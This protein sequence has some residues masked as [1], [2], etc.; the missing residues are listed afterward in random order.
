MVEIPTILHSL[1]AVEIE[2]GEKGVTV[3]LGVKWIN[4]KNTEIELC[5]CLNGQHRIIG[6]AIITDLWYGPFFSLPARF[7]EKEHEISSRMYSGLMKSMQRA[8]G[9]K[10]KDDSL[11]VAL[12]YEREVKTFNTY[13][14]QYCSKCGL[15]AKN[16]PIEDWRDMPDKTCECK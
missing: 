14:G 5:E 7:I 1:H 4:S 11:V 12:E 8:Y 2:P 15:L 16:F 6:K 9:S 13:G 3:R 10:F